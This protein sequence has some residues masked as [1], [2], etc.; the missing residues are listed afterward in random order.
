MTSNNNIK[1][2][3]NTEILNDKR[4]INAL[5]LINEIGLKGIVQDIDD[6]NRYAVQSGK[7]GSFYEV[8]FLKSGS[9]CS[10]M[11]YTFNVEKEG[12][13]CKHIQAIE[14]LKAQKTKFI[15]GVLNL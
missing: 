11:D 8:M 5:S 14:I 7:T 15:K 12:F 13:K 3:D 2:V 4:K 6:T 10:C 9:Y 1:Y